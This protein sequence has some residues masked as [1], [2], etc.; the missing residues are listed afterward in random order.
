MLGWDRVLKKSYKARHKRW[1]SEK[2]TVGQSAGAG[3]EGDS[4]LTLV[5]LCVKL[6]PGGTASAT[7]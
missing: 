3:A 2:G 1:G 4:D 6:E 5:C 7:D